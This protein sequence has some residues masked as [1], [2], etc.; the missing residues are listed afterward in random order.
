MPRKSEKQ[1]NLE[2][3]VVDQ[4]RRTLERF[5]LQVD[6][7]TK[8]SFTSF[9]SAEAVG[10]TIKSAHPIVQVAVYDAEEHQQKII[11]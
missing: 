10:K 4:K 7:Q 1:D 11:G 2:V 5:R 3:V 9:E 8:A 6:R